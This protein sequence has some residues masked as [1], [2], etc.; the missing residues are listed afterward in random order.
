MLFHQSL[1]WAALILVVAKSAA[2]PPSTCNAVRLVSDEVEQSVAFVPRVEDGSAHVR[3]DKRVW[4]VILLST[5]FAEL[6][7]LSQSKVWLSQDDCSAPP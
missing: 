1:S 6:A 3:R 5:Q 2:L 4:R 7:R